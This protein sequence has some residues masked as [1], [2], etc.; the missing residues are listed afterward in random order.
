[1]RAKRQS[2]LVFVCASVAL[3]LAT[4]VW[5]RWAWSLPDPGF[6]LTLPD[7]IELGVV[8]GTQLE[9]PPATAQPEPPPPPPAPANADPPP[10]RVAEAA[11]TEPPAPQPPKPKPPKKPSGPDA[12]TRQSVAKQGLAAVSPPG[13][14]LALRLDLD[15]I[16]DSPLSD[17]VRDL[18]DG[19]PDVRAI[20]DGSEVEPVRDLSR[21]FLASPNLKRSSVV[22]AGKY[23]GDDSIARAAAENLA[24]ARG[25]SLAWETRGTIPVAPWENP[26]PTE[27]VLA[28]FGS[29]LFAITRSDDLPRVIAIGQ[30]LAERRKNARHAQQPAEALLAMKDGELVTFTAENAKVFVRGGSANVPDRLSVAAHEPQSETLDVRSEA[31]FPTE[32]EAARALSFWDEMRTRYARSPLVAL[33][34]IG[35]LL[36]RTTLARKGKSLEVRATL[37]LEEVRLI[38]RFVRDSLAQR[39]APPPLPTTLDEDPPRPE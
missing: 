18:L 14:Q 16:R 31:E 32:A 3:H 25:K 17:D 10:A 19:I 36:E 13:A 35:G 26:D 24:R 22:L 8:E 38:L 7:T 11:K 6:E 33:L 2:V 15:K 12:A 29:G 27:R 23:R 21:L 4:Y 1:M 30:A 37:Q 28:L 20:L 39:R 5:M 34:G 9:T